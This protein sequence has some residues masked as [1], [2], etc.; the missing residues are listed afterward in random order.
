MPWKSLRPE[1]LV[2]SMSPAELLDSVRGETAIA[3]DA[4]TAFDFALRQW[5]VAALSRVDDVEGLLVLDELAATGLRKLADR[6]ANADTKVRWNAFR[7]LLESKRLQAAGAQSG[8]AMHSRRAQSRHSRMR[9]PAPRIACA[10]TALSTSRSR[11]S[12]WGTCCWCAPASW[13]RPT[14]W[15]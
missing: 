4:L 6:P 9:R 14:A 3:G 13:W 7:D 8:R 12:A 5:T 1:S 10:A 15:L 11:M 2:D